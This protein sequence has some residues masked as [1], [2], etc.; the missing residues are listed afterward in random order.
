MQTIYRPYKD[1]HTVDPLR[2]IFYI[3]QHV[4]TGIYYAGYKTNDKNMMTSDGYCTSSNKV[5]SII[6]EEGLNSF[7]IRRIQYFS[8]GKEAHD[9]ETEFLI[10]VG[11]PKNSRFYN[12]HVNGNFF[13]EDH[14]YKIGNKNNLGKRRSTEAKIKMSL[15]KRGKRY[16]GSKPESFRR[17][18][19]LI[20][21]GKVLTEKTR[22][23]LRRANVGK[24]HSPETLAKMRLSQQLR[25]E[26]EAQTIKL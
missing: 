11:V 1:G 6:H 7:I 4:R 17:K 13:V 10:R 21:K 8:T 19:S 14:S 18:M 12:R 25:R 15:A 24:H 20:H 2:P 5:K 3:I 16:P 22:E 26:R 23:K 9:H